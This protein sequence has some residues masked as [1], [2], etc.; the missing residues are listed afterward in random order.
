MDSLNRDI[1]ACFGDSITVGRP[2]TSYLKYLKYKRN[3]RNFGLGGDT[4]LGLSKRIDDFLMESS[5][6]KFIIE[7]GCNDILLP[8]LRDCSKRWTKVVDKIIARGS[9]PLSKSSDFTAQYEKLIC[10]LSDKKIIIVSIPCIGENLENDLNQKVVEY[11]GSIKNLCKKYG[12][13]YIDFNVW[14]RE[15]INKEPTSDYFI[16]KNP[17][18][19]IL[20]SFTTADLGLS[21]WISKKRKLTVTVDG[22]HLNE[23]G[24]KGLAYLIEKDFGRENI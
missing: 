12:I 8:Y 6:D 16:T 23:E 2:G 9:V 15:K 17:F 3:Y 5:C 7:I 4:L 24:A 14:Q 1:I 19:M 21:S 20:D 13:T 18:N 11:N 22:V 10:K